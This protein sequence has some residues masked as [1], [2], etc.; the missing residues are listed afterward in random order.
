ME[1]CECS[2]VP[3]KNTGSAKRRQRADSAGRGGEAYERREA[4]ESGGRRGSAARHTIDQ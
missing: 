3:Q 1:R 4:Y 2:G